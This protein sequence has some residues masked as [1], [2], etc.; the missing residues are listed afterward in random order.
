[1]EDSTTYVALDTHKKE[2]QVAM[3]LAGEKQIRQWKVLNRAQDIRR[4][5]KKIQKEAPGAIRFCYEAGPC[6]FDLQRKLISLGVECQVIAPS[7][8]PRKPGERIKTDRRD[9]R[10]LLE[11]QK[12]GML[13]EVHP[14]SA[15]E[16]AIRD[17]CRCREAV[18]EDQKRAQHR[19]L[20]FLLRHGIYFSEGANWTQ[21]H[22]RWLQALKF[23]HK[24]EELVFTEYL[25]EVHRQK[26]RLELLE[27]ELEQV[28]QREPYREGVA[29]L[30]CFQGID[31]ITA[32]VI[33]SELFGF[34]R[35]NKPRQLMSFL[36]LVPSE[37]SSGEKG[38]QGGITKTG[39]RRVRRV[40][41]EASWHY[42]HKPT[43]GK[44]LQRRRKG[45][46]SWAIEQADKAR[47]R[48]YRKYWRL[49]EKGKNPNQAT[50]AVARE[51]AGFL[52]MILH[53]L[54]EIVPPGAQGCTGAG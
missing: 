15:Q 4:M 53:T 39:N 43:V 11:Y 48:L 46:P 22:L 42:R 37:H 31:T 29:L 33:V 54:I 8:I 47:K 32:M 30:R 50:A 26:H 52:W 20:K 24:I 49:V 12:A 34:E 28:S 44:S 51:L 35:F 17:L 10:K 16:E 23:E 36:G 38:R 2:H 18:K 7:L 40:L 41:I 6:G 45:Q 13:T 9:A 14:P 27:Q 5:V 3:V 21:K 19:L 1:M 25:C